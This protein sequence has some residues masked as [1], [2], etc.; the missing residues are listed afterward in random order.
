MNYESF[1]QKLF[2]RKILAGNIWK[3]EVELINP[4][5]R[6]VKVNTSNLV[7]VMLRKLKERVH[8]MICESTGSSQWVR[9]VSLF[10]RYQEIRQFKW[11]FISL[12]TMST[13]DIF[14]IRLKS[15]RF[16]AEFLNNYV[17]PALDIYDDFSV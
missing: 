14:P 15:L 9:F 3:N 12:T 16:C 10:C 1:A 7:E 5:A 6:F 4:C 13:S 8:F 2:V 17:L 11:Y